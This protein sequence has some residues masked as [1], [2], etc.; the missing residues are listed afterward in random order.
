[1]RTL[2]TK[3]RTEDGKRWFCIWNQ[4]ESGEVFNAMHV[5]IED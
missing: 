2:W 3:Y 5:K 4:N 1:M